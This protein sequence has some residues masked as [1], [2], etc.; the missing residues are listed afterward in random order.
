MRIVLKNFYCRTLAGAAQGSAWQSKLGWLAGWLAGFRWPDL[1]LGRTVCPTITPSRAAPPK[2]NP[3]GDLSTT[4]SRTLRLSAAQRGAGLGAHW[5]VAV[6]ALADDAPHRTALHCAMLVQQASK[7]AIK[8]AK[9]PSPS[10]P[11]V[12]LLTRCRM[13]NARCQNHRQTAPHRTAPHR[14]RSSNGI[15]SS[16]PSPLS[17]SFP[18]FQPLHLTSPTRPN[19]DPSVARSH[20]PGWLRR[21][22]RYRISADVFRPAPVLFF[23]CSFFVGG[24]G[25]IR[26]VGSGYLGCFSGFGMTR[27]TRRDAARQVRW[28]RAGGRAGR[29]DRVRCEL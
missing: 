17:L 3:P 24:G 23:F 22:S 16:P 7:Q 11:L 20:P 25:G 10:P 28:A 1:A 21:S 8:H 26:Y 29:T 5:P 19:T 9:P 27:M 13:P 6:Q 2:P 15:P 14:T 4:P 12:R 18:S